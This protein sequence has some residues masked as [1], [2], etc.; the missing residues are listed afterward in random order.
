MHKLTK[1]QN[2]VVFCNK[3]RIYINAGAG[4]GKTCTI[5]T[6]IAQRIEEA[7]PPSNILVLAYNKKIQQEIQ[8]KVPRNVLVCTFHAFAK[9]E[10]KRY[11][12]KVPD[13]LSPEETEA[14]II[15]A[16]KETKTKGKS[17][18]FVQAVLAA[19][20]N[21]SYLKKFKPA[22][23]TV[24][25]RYGSLLKETHR[26]DFAKLIRKLIFVLK[27][28]EVFLKELQS[29]Y[30]HIYIDEFQ[31]ISRKRLK[32]LECLTSERT[33]LFCV[34]DSDQSIYGWNGIDEKNVEIAIKILKLRVFN[35]TRSYR[36]P[37]KIVCAV[38]QLLKHNQNPLRKSL[39]SAKK[40]DGIIKVLS[41]SKGE[42]EISFIKQKIKALR[43][44]G[45]LDKDIALLF[46]V[47]KMCT[48]YKNCLQVNCYFSTVHQAKGLEFKYVFVVGA[49]DG[50]FPCIP[51][52]NKLSEK[53]CAAKM[54]E[55]RRVF[56]EAITRAS[57]GV[58]ITHLNNCL[59][60]NRIATP[61]PFLSELKL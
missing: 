58:Y 47:K 19:R 4:T 40:A 57:K 30:T 25:E 27:K 54:R 3:P 29:R 55:E 51:N 39:T 20:E 59:R 45:I 50:L 22:Y 36:L 13:L 56:A 43:Q 5:L 12:Q 49:E 35:L 31:D 2:D 14:L 1:E 48:E 10:L 21:P 38:N 33:H 46:R 6:S 52:M 37:T 23:R 44:K 60:K 41:F 53:E 17:E 24:Y 26:F 32:L 61:S 42:E 15:R 11:M 16:K 7:V 9:K 18:D 34:G 28:D 8:K